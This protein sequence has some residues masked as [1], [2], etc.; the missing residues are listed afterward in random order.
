MKY[1]IIFLAAC[2]LLTACAKQ[3]KPTIVPA[4]APVVPQVKKEVQKPQPSRPTNIIGAIEP[5]YILPMKSA[6]YARVDTGAMTSSVDIENLMRF[7]RDGEKWVAFD[8]VNSRSKE[9]Y[10][11]E[12]PLLKR[13]KIKR[14]GKEEHRL[15]VMLD[16]KLGGKK[17]K[18]PFTLAERADFEYQGL[19]GRS[20][21]SGRYIVDTSLEYTLK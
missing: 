15:K 19:L 14:I 6:F 3:E 20:V 11:F 13:V 2:L 4:I 1:L 7:E 5:F 17:I 16:I 9:T 8:I 10:H 18:T 12:R 21:L